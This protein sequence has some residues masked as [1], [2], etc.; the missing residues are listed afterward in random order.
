MSDESAVEAGGQHNDREHGLDR[1]IKNAARAR[2]RH[3]AAPGEKNAGRMPESLQAA[4]EVICPALSSSAPVCPAHTATRQEL[5]QRRY[6]FGAPSDLALQHGAQLVLVT[7][8]DPVVHLLPVL[9]AMARK[10][11]PLSWVF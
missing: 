9:A 7:E 10:W 5:G 6:V 4:C 1:G 8:S 2:E 11:S 3:T